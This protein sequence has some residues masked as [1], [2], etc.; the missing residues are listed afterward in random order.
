MTSI[1]TYNGASVTLTKSTVFTF[2]PGI[3]TWT[4]QPGFPLSKDTFV[5]PGSPNSPNGLNQEIR[6]TRGGAELLIQFDL[7]P[8]PTGSKI[9]SWFG[10]SQLQSGANLMLHRNNATSAPGSIIDVMLITRSWWDLFATW[11]DYTLLSPWPSQGIGYDLRPV[12]T[13]PFLTDALSWQSLDLTNA[14]T[15]WMNGLY[16][17][18]GVWI[19]AGPGVN[20]A[21]IALSE[22]GAANRPK[23]VVSYLLPCGASAP[24]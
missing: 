20:N 15:A 9:V 18:N 16:P 4:T 17:N 23:L 2:Q 10:A 22:A 19:R 13:N 3:R 6:L 12:S 24:P 11:N 7:S 5:D 1:G 21:K 14:A 8:L